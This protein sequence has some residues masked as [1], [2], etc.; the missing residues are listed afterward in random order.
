MRMLAVLLLLLL[1]WS[2]QALALALY[3][4]FRWLRLGT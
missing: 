1:Y 3:T 2:V 4:G